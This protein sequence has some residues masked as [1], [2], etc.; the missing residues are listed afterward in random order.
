MSGEILEHLRTRGSG[1]VTAREVACEL[2]LPRQS[3]AAVLQGLAR[4]GDLEQTTVSWISNR[5]RVRSCFAYRCRYVTASYPE[6]LMPAA[7]HPPAGVG[8]IIRFGE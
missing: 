8:R 4:R 3:A 5:F 2:G 7:S 6:W 1:W